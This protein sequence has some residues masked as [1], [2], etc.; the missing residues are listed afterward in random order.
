MSTETIPA[1]P[2]TEGTTEA[3]DPS[4]IEAS[5]AWGMSRE[6]SY[7]VRIPSR[8]SEPVFRAFAYLDGLG[9]YTLGWNV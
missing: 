2:P 6:G 4:T 7:R 8:L 9:F 1:E 5:H 3:L